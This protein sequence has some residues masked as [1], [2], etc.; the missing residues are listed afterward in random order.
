MRGAPRRPLT[1]V[2]GNVIYARHM[3]DP[4]AVLQLPTTNPGD[5]AAQ[6]RTLDALRELLV[7]LAADVQLLR[8]HRF[9][10]ADAYEQQQQVQATP[11]TGA[12]TRYLAEQAADLDG[13]PAVPQ[14]WLSVA[15]RGGRSRAAERMG[16]L[17]VDP[18][19]H[20]EEAR[21]ALREVGMGAWARDQQDIDADHDRA[22]DVLTRIASF[23]PG[24]R[25][26]SVPEV[27]WL[28]RR[29]WTRGLG[30]PLVDG[31]G[32]PRALY[33]ERNG[34]SVLRPVQVDLLAWTDC[35]Q[36]GYRQLHCEGELGTSLQAGL[37]ASSLPGDAPEASRVLQILSAPQDRLGF[38][39]D[40]SLC[41]S[42]VSPGRA[43]K[44]VDSE[45]ARADE[46][47]REEHQATRGASDQ[48]LARADVAR[49]AE[50]YLAGGQPLFELTFTAIVAAPD[51]DSLRLRVRETVA[52]LRSH[53]VTLRQPA[54][55]QLAVFFEQLPAQRPWTTGFVRRATA[56]QLA[57]TAP[58]SAHRLGGTHGYAWGVA[59]PAGSGPVA[60]WCPQD[61]SRLNTAAGVLMVGDSGAGKTTAAAK[62]AMEAFLDGAVIFDFTAKSDDHHWHTRTPV[63]EH[64]DVI[65]LDADH[66]K[67][68]GLLDPWCNAPVELRR[69]SALDFL[70]ALLP[71][72]VSAEWQTELLLA[73]DAVA[74]REAAPCNELVLA[75]L[76]QRARPVSQA[77]AEHLRAQSRSGMSQL[78]FAQPGRTDIAGTLGSRQVTHVQL[79]HLPVP[80]RGI[81]RAAYDELERQGSALAKLVA[82]LGLG[83]L[84]RHP[85]QAKLF[86]FDE[87]KVLL[88]HQFGRKLIDQL[89][90][91]GRSK[92]A[93]PVLQT[94]YASDIGLDRDSVGALFGTVFCFRAPSEQEAIRSLDLL[95]RAP[96]GQ[97]IRDLQS[98]PSGRALVRDHRGQIEW[99]QVM[100][101]PT[102][103]EQ[104]QTNPHQR[105]RA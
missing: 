84:A 10:D 23:L 68:R 26:A 35:V 22:A 69:D 51:Q 15:L 60:R 29:A 80:E 85:D 55:Q 99:L 32:Q 63:D 31:L 7:D 66:A 101:P 103:A 27:E 43:G 78:G 5:E 81:D 94:Q 93:V 3:R 25:P 87:V 50:A 36:S 38:P 37:I 6:L 21:A 61:G 57:A 8:T 24:T 71:R 62:L 65:E 67:W 18:A 11:H 95:G 86:N 72:G 12:R 53:G 4:W 79:E 88:D 102:L 58:T 41:A 34:Q 92:K 100:L 28:V 105:T 14:V 74:E 30:E 42:Y 16:E 90:R 89:Q 97:L 1:W 83:I 39:I 9:W 73:V 98:A 96:T 52:C 56:D 44:A 104:V 64:C 20:V 54:A 46:A 47:A 59:G 48:A 40:L 2:S 70:S 77:I 33:F 13:L 75:A 82:M 49:D 45:R 17:L 76:E 91:L 19:A